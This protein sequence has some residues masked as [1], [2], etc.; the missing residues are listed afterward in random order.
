MAER[1]VAFDFVGHAHSERPKLNVAAHAQHAS[2]LGAALDTLVFTDVLVKPANLWI[3]RKAMTAMD[4]HSDWRSLAACRSADPELFFPISLSGCGAADV[5]KAK[6]ICAKCDVRAHCLSTAL[7]LGHVHGIWGGT[8]EED[9]QQLRRQG[10]GAQASAKNGT[11][12][13]EDPAAATAAGS[14]VERR[15]RAAR[16]SLRRPGRSPR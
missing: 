7:A 8:T 5:A 4:D 14:S 2:Q 15:A 9:R 13:G 16:K 11:H 6:A 3:A 1:S 10:D 12:L